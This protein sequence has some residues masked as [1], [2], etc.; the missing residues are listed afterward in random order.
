MISLPKSRTNYGF[1]FLTFFFLELLELWEEKNNSNNKQ[2][3][4]QKL[5]RVTVKQMLL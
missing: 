4:K 1:C 3:N 5:Q 2:T